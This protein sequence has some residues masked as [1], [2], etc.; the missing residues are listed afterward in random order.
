MTHLLTFSC[1]GVRLPG[2]PRGS[3]DRTRANHRG[4]PIPPNMPLRDYAKSK[5]IDPPATLSPTEANLV[6]SALQE[7]CAHRGWCLRA[8]HVR[9]THVHL[10]LD[11]A[12][13]PNIVMATIKA[14]ATRRLRE[15]GTQGAR[16]SR[17]GNAARLP[18]E[19]AIQ[20]AIRYVSSQQGP[21][22]ALYVAE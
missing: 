4:G 2:D 22:I 19:T 16:W 8:V 14:W 15:K 13:A 10:V 12:T 6:L 17:G 11:A 3:V 18:T 1:Y 5:Q 7:V 20:N 21:P 9:T